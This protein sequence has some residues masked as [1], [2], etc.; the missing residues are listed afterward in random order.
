MTTFTPIIQRYTL[1][2][3]VLVVA[4][5]RIEGTWKAY[6]D[7]VLGVDHDVEM[8][9]VLRHGDDVGEYVARHLFPGFADMPYAD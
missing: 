4:Q 5:T 6:C 8:D 9:A 1:A 3:R 2:S 7:A